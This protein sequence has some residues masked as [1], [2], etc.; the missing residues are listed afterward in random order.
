MKGKIVGRTAKP[1]KEKGAGLTGF[2]GIKVKGFSVKNVVIRYFQETLRSDEKNSEEAQLTG[3][4]PVT[5]ADRW[6][7]HAKQTGYTYMVDFAGY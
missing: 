4:P 3:K 6:R 5:F 2:H 1:N 7:E